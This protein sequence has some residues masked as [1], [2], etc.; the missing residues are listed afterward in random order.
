MKEALWWL[1]GNL[2]WCISEANIFACDSDEERMTTCVRTCGMARFHMSSEP[3]YF[4]TSML[5][6]HK[7][8]VF[9]GGDPI[10]GNYKRLP[11]HFGI[12]IIFVILTSTT[13]LRHQT[14][15]E[16]MRATTSL[17][18]EPI[19]TILPTHKGG[20]IV[21][22][23]KA[24]HKAKAL[25]QLPDTATCTPLTTDPKPKQ[26]G[27]IQTNLGILMRGYILPAPR[28][29]DPTDQAGYFSQTQ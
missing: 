24:D 26:T 23:N 27:A 16:E 7:W 29:A 22:I 2:Q 6:H 13:H 14:T 8:H 25:Q 10:I 28:M 12:T 20:S 15:A 11:C 1:K 18:N 21:L 9:C 3:P 4:L 17:K 5:L 19:I